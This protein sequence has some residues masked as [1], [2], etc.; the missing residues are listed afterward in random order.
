MLKCISWMK[1]LEF[2]LK[3]HWNLFIRVQLTMFKHWFRY[4][5]GA[6]QATSHYLNQWWLFYWRIYA[7]LGLNELMFVVD[8]G[9]ATRLRGVSLPTRP[10]RSLVALWVLATNI[11]IKSFTMNNGWSLWMTWCGYQIVI[12]NCYS[13]GLWEGY[14]FGFLVSPVSSDGPELLGVRE[15]DR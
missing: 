1:M 12:Q 15:S 5:L 7:S 13:R 11:R 8:T 4:W 14:L 6:D 9:S 3:F 2:R 10:P